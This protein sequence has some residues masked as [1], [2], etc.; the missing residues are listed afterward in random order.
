MQKTHLLS[1]IL[2]FLM[3]GAVFQTHAQVDMP[4]MEEPQPSTE[5]QLAAQFYQ[6][7]AFQKSA[8]LYEKI[9][10]KTP[11]NFIYQSLLNCYVGLKDVKSGEKLINRQSKKMPGALNYGVDLGSFYQRI[12]ETAKAEKQFE[13]VIKETPMSDAMRVYELLE[14][15]KSKKLNQYA[16]KTI[17]YSRK[18]GGDKFHYE[19]AE[20]QAAQSQWANMMNEYE[21]LIK[22]TGYQMLDRIESNLQDILSNDTNGE[23]SAIV[24]ERL[25]KSAQQKP[26]QIIYAEILIWLSLQQR[27]FD[28]ALAQ[29]KSIDKR[30]N[31]SGY[32]LMELATLCASNLAYDVAAKALK[33]VIEKGQK[34]EFY[35]TARRE[36]A[37]L[38]YQTVVNTQNPTP[39]LI[40]EAE[41]SLLQMMNDF[42]ISDFSLQPITQWAHIKAFYQNKSNEGRTK[43]EKVVKT[44]G[45]NTRFL[46][47]AKLEL[48]DILL[49]EGDVWESTLLYSQ[50]EKAFKNDTLGQ[51]AKFRNAK[52]AYYKGEFEWAK[53]QLDILKQ[54]TSKLIANDAMEL[55]LLLSD[56]LAFDTTG[57]ALRFF[58]RADLWQFQKQ[59]DK[60][61]NT[62]DSIAQF[63]PQS[64]LGDDIKYRKGLLFESQGKFNEA[65][66]E[67][68]KLLAAHRADILADNALYRLALLQETKLK[69]TKKAMELYQELMTDFPGSLFQVDARK[70]FRMLRGDAVN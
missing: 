62:L 31:E 50:V 58:A 39:I 1:L 56:N 28:Q 61:L 12:G 69:D 36:L 67:Y 4:E 45:L 13:K 24:R 65:I 30:L 14:S 44:N 2:F 66:A 27:D 10:D 55:S 25:L 46:N 60:A 18:N 5:E 19:M 48:A 22:Q 26:D 53:A 20:L 37:S 17:E 63:F 41:L 47:Q 38:L 35:T 59:S 16:L 21:D 32:R 51:E 33:V 42:G 8:D 68:E 52:L 70:R 23:I 49:L 15:F 7:G 34:S 9:Y 64:S 57:E 6:E 11:T 29:T 40:A 43:L 54:A 3:C